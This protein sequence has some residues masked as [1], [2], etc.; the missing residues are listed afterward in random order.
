M[1]AEGGAGHYPTA[2]VSSCS[3][4]AQGQITSS[5]STGLSAGEEGR[6]GARQQPGGVGM[7]LQNELGCH[8]TGY[9]VH[10]PPLEREQDTLRLR[11]GR[12]QHVRSKQFIFLPQLLTEGNIKCH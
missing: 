5:E 12:T 3:V 8:Q 2:G 9:L 6:A 4:S 11:D 1:T 10:S 7:L